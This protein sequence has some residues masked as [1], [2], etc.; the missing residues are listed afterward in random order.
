MKKLIL[1][2]TASVVLMTNVC[3][4]TNN[5][6][7]QFGADVNTVTQA[8]YKDYTDGK[9]SEINQETLNYYFKTFLPNYDTARLEDFNAIFSTLKNADNASII[10]NSNYSEEGQAFLQKS[11][12][13]YSITKLVE[14]V[15]N[16]KID[17]K[18][19]EGILSVLAI[20]YNLIK[21]YFDGNLNPSGKGSHEESDAF[22]FAPV[23][24]KQNAE[25]ANAFIW[26]GFGA[27]TGFNICGLTCGVIGGAIGLVIG[28]WMD[29][30]GIKPHI[31]SGGSSSGGGYWNP[32]P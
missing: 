17:E 1:G 8:M 3:A 4:Q 22:D 32:Q 7:N 9:F 29:S 15:K 6:Y 25:G 5:P 23:D 13:H 18:E 24:F 14:E 31:S 2:F 11:L 26:G 12:E 16:S 10:K 21:T 27:I 20:N 28:G 30:R 19:K